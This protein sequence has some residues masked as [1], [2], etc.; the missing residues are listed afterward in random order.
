LSPDTQH[1]AAVSQIHVRRLEVRAVGIVG[2]NAAGQGAPIALGIARLDEETSVRARSF[3]HLE[4]AS[5]QEARL[6]YDSA[7]RG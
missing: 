7:Q 2:A 3:A 5:Q 6:R 4:V 1:R